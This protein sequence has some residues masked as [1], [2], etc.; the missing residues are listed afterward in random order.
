VGVLDGGA[1]TPPEAW[2]VATSP[3]GQRIARRAA[4]RAARHEDRLDAAQDAVEAIYRLALTHD[5]EKGTF[6]AYAGQAVRGRIAR[7]R[8][9]HPVAGEAARELSRRVRKER[10]RREAQGRPVGRVELAATLGIGLDTLDACDRLGRP[11]ARLDMPARFQ[12]GEG[13]LLVET[14][15]S[16]A[17]APDDVLERTETRARVRRALATLPPAD[18]AL[19]LS[20]ADGQH[21]LDELAAVR[22]CAR[23][24]IRDQ[25]HRAARELR[26]ALLS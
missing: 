24:Q 18:R 2:A 15:P 10:A 13:A 4:R 21:S 22:G 25:L 5:P 26:R 8:D 7:P 19:L 23:G 17:P 6:A 9:G 14:L 11:V 16:E 3:T 1:V 12:D 20:R